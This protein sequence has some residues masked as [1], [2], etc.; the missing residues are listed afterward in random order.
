M[1]TIKLYLFFG[2][3]LNNLYSCSQNTP[4]KTNSK[5]EK[6]I[7][8]YYKKNPYFFPT[9]DTSFDR[10]GN[11]FGLDLGK[12]ELNDIFDSISHKSDIVIYMAGDNNKIDTI[13]DKIGILLVKIEL[14]RGK[15]K[16]SSDTAAFNF[17]YANNK[18]AFLKYEVRY[19]SEVKS[20]EPILSADKKRFRDWIENLK[21]QNR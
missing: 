18:W 3:L 7:L 2:L 21:L 17:E 8:L 12:I 9:T 6:G 14:K 20:I 16:L 11:S 1:K 5:S 19:D 13:K 4:Q 15:T 10:I